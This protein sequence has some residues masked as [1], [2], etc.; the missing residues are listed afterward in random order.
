LRHSKMEC[1][2]TFGP[3]S[4]Q[5]TSRR[6]NVGGFLGFGLYSDRGH[7]RLD[8]RDTH[9]PSE[10]V[11]EHVE[12]HLGSNFGLCHTLGFPHCCSNGFEFVDAETFLRPTCDV[13][14]LCLT[15][16]RLIAHAQRSGDVPYRRRL[17]RAWIKDGGIVARR[18]FDPRRIGVE[19]F[20]FL[21]LNPESPPILFPLYFS[22]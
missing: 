10:I 5:N 12:C 3:W 13:G 21:F 16:R 18:D 7:Q 6:D 22:M 14:E 8:A 17:G 11:S 1:S 9:Y 15:G 2:T 20:D 19:P 4:C